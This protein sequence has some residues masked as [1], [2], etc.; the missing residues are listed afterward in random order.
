MY[1]MYD[2]GP[3]ITPYSPIRVHH[4]S[5]AKFQSLTEHIAAGVTLVCGVVYGPVV[6]YE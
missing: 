4:W 6:H 3:E 5:T 2:L 1:Y